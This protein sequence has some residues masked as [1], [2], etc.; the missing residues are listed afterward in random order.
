VT[1]YAAANPADVFDSS[2][3]GWGIR[4]YFRGLL[5]TVLAPLGGGSGIVLNDCIIG[6]WFCFGF[7]EVVTGVG[8][9]NE[10]RFVNGFTAVV[11]LERPL[12][13]LDPFRNRLVVLNDY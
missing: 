12:V 1:S 7:A 4:R 5:A 8:L 11:D 9:G 3:A 10:V 13:W 2:T 6:L